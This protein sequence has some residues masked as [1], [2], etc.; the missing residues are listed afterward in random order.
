IERYHVYAE[1]FDIRTH[2]HEAVPLLR[3]IY[4]EHGASQLQLQFQYG[5]HIFTAGAENKVTVRMEYDEAKDHYVFHRVKRSLQWETQ[6][7]AHLSALGLETADRQLGLLTPAATSG[8]PV[9]V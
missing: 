1:G 9:S 8:K 6:Q 3:L 5:P 7:Q 2:Q 4:I